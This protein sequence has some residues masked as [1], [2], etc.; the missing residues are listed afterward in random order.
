MLCSSG[1]VFIVCFASL[2]GVSFGLT[3]AGSRS[4]VPVGELGTC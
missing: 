4:G 1:R 2:T 3:W